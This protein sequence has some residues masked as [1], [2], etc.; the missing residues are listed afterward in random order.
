M[1][2]KIYSRPGMI[3]SSFNIFP[4]IFNVGISSSLGGDKELSSSSEEIKNKNRRNL[5]HL[6]KK[7]TH[8][9]ES[10]TLENAI[11]QVKRFL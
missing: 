3:S 5:K 8:T 1:L 4:L 2:L 11:W 10:Y 7:F 6:L 9:V